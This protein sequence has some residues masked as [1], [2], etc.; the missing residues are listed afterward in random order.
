M[1]NDYQVMPTPRHLRADLSRFGH[2]AVI[3]N[4]ELYI[5]GGFDGIM[6]N[7]M[8]K[9]NFFYIQTKHFFKFSNQ[10]DSERVRVMCQTTPNASA[11]QTES[12][13]CGTE[14]RHPV[15]RSPKS[16]HQPLPTT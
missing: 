6:R 5:Y 4:G 11:A 3:F 7:D 15:F 1:L 14:T 12:N 2:S 10:P 16:P 13:A 9:Y 8:I